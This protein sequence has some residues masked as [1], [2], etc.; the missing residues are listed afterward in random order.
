MSFSYVYQRV[1]LIGLWSRRRCSELVEK[2]AKQKTMKVA[3]ELKA[4]EGI[5]FLEPKKEGGMVE[6]R[7]ASISMEFKVFKCHGKI[8]N[9]N[10]V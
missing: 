3:P 8:R 2:V 7:K 1:G 6:L 10:G 9:I 4:V 5:L